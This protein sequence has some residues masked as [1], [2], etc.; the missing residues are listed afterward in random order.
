MLNKTVFRS[1]FGDVSLQNQLLHNLKYTCT[2]GMF[3]GLQ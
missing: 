1:I 2:H 3:D